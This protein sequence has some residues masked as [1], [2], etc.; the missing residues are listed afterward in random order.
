MRDVSV[1]EIFVGLY[2]QQR[3]GMRYWKGHTMK[4]DD[5]L[6]SLAKAAAVDAY[7]E[8]NAEDYGKSDV[9]GAGEL[10]RKL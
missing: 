9:A 2:A 7:R 6:F 4:D 1:W 10:S 8:L 5:A 3:R